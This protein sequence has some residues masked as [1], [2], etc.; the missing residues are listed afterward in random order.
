MAGNFS[1]P[2]IFCP[3]EEKSTDKYG[4]SYAKAIWSS[5]NQY[6]TTFNARRERFINNRRY[7]EGLE[8]IEKYKELLDTNGDTSYLNLD[9]SPV[10][11]IA[12]IVDNIHGKMMNQTYKIQCNAIDPESKIE[13]DKA[14]DE[15]YANMLLKHLAPDFAERTGLPLVPPSQEIPDTDDEAEIYF[16]LNFKQSSAIAMEQAISYVLMNNSFE[17]VRS[18]LIRDLIVLK[19]A[20]V[21]RF[22]DENN[23]IRVEYVDPVDLI[24]PYSKYDDFRNI[25]WVGVVKNYT[26]QEISRRTNKFDAKQLEEIARLNQGKNG[27][28]SW[29]FSW[30]GSYEGY[31]N[32]SSTFMTR[33]Y[34]NFN[35]QVLEFEFLT[36]D[37]EVRAK[38]YNQKG[39][40]FFN[41]KSSKYKPSEGNNVEVVEKEIQYRYAGSWIIGTDYI[42]SYEKC[43]NLE[44]EFNLSADKKKSYYPNVDLSYTIIAPGIYDMENKSLVE[45]MIPH[46]DQLNLLNL[47]KQ[48]LLIKAK[49]PG[50]SFDVEALANVIKGMGN[51]SM[52]PL[53]I[54]RIYEQTGSFPTSSRDAEGNV[55]NS[56]GIRELANGISRDY[57]LL[58][59]AQQHEIALMNDV[60]GYNTAVD[61]SSPNAEALVGVQRMAVQAT[62]NALRPLYFALTKVI[63]RNA[64]KLSL[65]IQDSIEFNYDSFVAAIG[66]HA[67]KTIEYGKKLAL[68]QLGIK[69][70]FLPDEEERQQIEA[71]ISLGQQAGVLMPSD[72][73]RIRQVLKQDYKIAAQLL[74]V[75]EDKNRKNKQEEAK[76]LQEQNG[77]IQ[78]QSAQAAAEAQAQVSQVKS[79]A[80]QEVISLEYR[81]KMELSEQEH[82][83]KL[84]QIEKQNQGSQAIQGMKNEGAESVAEI[85]NDG[86]IKNE[87][88]RNAIGTAKRV[89]RI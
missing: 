11:R 6:S 21:R 64:A 69:V 25:P 51:G 55:I 20:A 79:Q 45:R 82:R 27:N 8:S 4:I 32:N 54:I 62:N 85:S 16:K 46:E 53:D 23:S 80:E 63:E 19:W 87:A 67:S 18:Q 74:V 60:I 10:N 43:K 75:L 73:I 13:E 58:L 86:K 84:E 7:A 42:Y 31:Y 89:N 52:T 48:H 41:K 2:D 47:K 81:L 40:F 33:P 30:N 26:I 65:M 37:K 22:Y 72:A 49:P 66:N 28:P 61:A 83:Q 5:Y 59:A 39:G 77:M 35:I 76:A 17:D 29:N 9:Y 12:S 71:Q 1:F 70:E 38:K 24:V 88:F 15:M 14:R 56:A 3:S 57:N 36:V 50:V 44:R 34:D 78:I 68:N